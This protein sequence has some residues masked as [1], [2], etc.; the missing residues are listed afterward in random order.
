MEFIIINSDD[1]DQLAENAIRTYINGCECRSSE[2]VG[3]VMLKLLNVAGQAMVAIQGQDIAVASM[4]GV[5]NILAM[6]D[7]SHLQGSTQLH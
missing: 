3:M 1:S 7:V 4:E 6:P 5:A 2:E